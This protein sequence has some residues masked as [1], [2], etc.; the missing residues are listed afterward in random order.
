MVFLVNSKQRILTRNN[1]WVAATDR[2][3]S[4]GTCLGPPKLPTA[5]AD[6]H[7]QAKFSTAALRQHRQH[8]G[9]QPDRNTSPPTQPATHNTPLDTCTRD[10]VTSYMD[11][12]LLRVNCYTFLPAKMSD[13]Y[14]LPTH[15]IT[16]QMCD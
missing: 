1:T 5:A 4:N 11:A 8:T 3:N 2:G 9:I 14:E 13:G 6:S 10:S 16:T 12:L 15:E 7:E